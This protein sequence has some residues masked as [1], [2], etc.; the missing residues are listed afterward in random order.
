MYIC[1]VPSW[2]FIYVSGFIQ[3][4]AWNSTF[5]FCPEAEF[6]NPPLCSN[7]ASGVGYFIPFLCPGKAIK[8]SERGPRQAQ[9]A[10]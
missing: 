5:S 7:Y 9:P 3:D 2:G 10:V 6:L 4:S 8:M 1:F